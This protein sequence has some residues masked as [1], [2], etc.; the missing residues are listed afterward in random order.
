MKK[1]QFSKKVTA[2]LV[3]GRPPLVFGGLC[4]ALAVMWTQNP[5]L[6][7]L[8]VVFLFTAMAFDLVD[9]WFAARF[10]P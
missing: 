10:Q 2:I 8:G 4:C 7:T 9:G 3:Y 5:V 6:Y 1:F